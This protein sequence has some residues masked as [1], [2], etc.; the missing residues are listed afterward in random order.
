VELGDRARGFEHR[1]RQ[2]NQRQR[3]QVEP[4]VD[5][6][7]LVVHPHEPATVRE[8]PA[9]R[10]LALVSAKNGGIDLHAGALDPTRR[11]RLFSLQTFSSMSA[12]AW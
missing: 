7:H 3:V 5:E 11:D 6:R 9:E 12:S 2:R 10:I 1:G 4:A 8:P